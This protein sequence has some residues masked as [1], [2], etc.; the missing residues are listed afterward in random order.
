MRRRKWRSRTRLFDARGRSVLVSANSKWTLT[1]AL[2]DGVVEQVRE[3]RPKR[4][5]QYETKRQREWGLT[6]AMAG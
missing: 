2:D 1:V 5:G 3:L 6:P 4:L